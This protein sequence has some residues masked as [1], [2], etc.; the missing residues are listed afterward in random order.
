VASFDL[1]NNEKNE[2][3][4]FTAARCPNKLWKLDAVNSA[5]LIRGTLYN[6]ITTS[7]YGRAHQPIEWTITTGCF[8]CKEGSPSTVECRETI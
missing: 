6:Y 4:N 2:R 5:Q 8:I 7:S 1:Q 3:M